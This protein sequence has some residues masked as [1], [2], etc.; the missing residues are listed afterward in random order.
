MTLYAHRFL[1]FWEDEAEGIKD[2]ERDLLI[3]DEMMVVRD[4][5]SEPAQQWMKWIMGLWSAEARLAH[6]SATKFGDTKFD[7]FVMGC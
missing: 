2:G 3:V 1:G 4:Q 7:P 6:H 5:E